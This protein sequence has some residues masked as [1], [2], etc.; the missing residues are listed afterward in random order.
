MALINTAVSASASVSTRK[1]IIVYAVSGTMYTVPTG[2]TF[3]GHVLASIGKGCQ[4]RINGVDLITL[5]PTTPY[6]LTPIPVT[7]TEG[8]VVS[9][10][11]SYMD[12]S[13]VGVES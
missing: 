8:T 10:G 4:A 2:R 12:W 11:A 3:Q 9:S 6:Y 5:S 13:L 1:T 7:L